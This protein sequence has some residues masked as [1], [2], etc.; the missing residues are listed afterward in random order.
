[1][2]LRGLVSLLAVATSVSMVQARCSTFNNPIRSNLQN[3]TDPQQHTKW[4]DSITRFVGER[5]LTS[6]GYGG[7]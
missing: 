3:P 5:S 1:M 6:A 4:K 7:G 2:F